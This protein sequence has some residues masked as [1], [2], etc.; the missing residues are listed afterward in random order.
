[1]ELANE[2]SSKGA[3]NTKRGVVQTDRSCYYKMQTWKIKKDCKNYI[4]SEMEK[5]GG[6]VLEENLPESVEQRGYSLKCPRFE[7]SG[8]FIG[9]GRIFSSQIKQ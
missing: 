3:Q 8:T 5:N 4:D 2:K 7:P 1:M 9:I 6:N